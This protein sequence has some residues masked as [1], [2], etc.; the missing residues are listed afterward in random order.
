[1]WV[2]AGAE[3]DLSSLQEKHIT[4]V[5]HSPPKS[6]VPLTVK[7]LGMS[8]P[9]GQAESLLCDG[10]KEAEGFAAWVAMHFSGSHRHR[11]EFRLLE[12]WHVDC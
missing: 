10:Y 3:V 8:S 11:M 4:R 1:M 7:A 6:W 5:C 12:K 9:H 2:G